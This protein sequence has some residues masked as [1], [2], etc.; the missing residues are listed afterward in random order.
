M[1]STT[2][3]CRNSCVLSATTFGVITSL[4]SVLRVTAGSPSDR[5]VIGSPVI[6]GACCRLD[7][8]RIHVLLTGVGSLY[9]VS[10]GEMAPNVRQ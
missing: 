2:V 5:Q 7:T 9:V 8:R 6:L 10:V 1:R 4:L 3:G